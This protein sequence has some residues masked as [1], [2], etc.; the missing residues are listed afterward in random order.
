MIKTLKRSAYK[1]GY[2][3]ITAAWLYT[4][5]FIFI[6]YLSYTSSPA[7]VKQQFE[8]YLQQKEKQVADFAGNASVL[9][10][11]VNDRIGNSQLALLDEDE[12]K[13]FVYQVNDVGNLLLTFWNTHEAAPQTADLSRADGKYF[14]VYPNGE[15]E[16]VKKSL[17]VQRS[18]VVIVALIPIRWNFFFKN[19]YLKTTFSG[20]SSLEN[21]YE[22]DV[23]NGAIQIKNGDGKVLFGLAEKE[24]RNQVLYDK[25]SLTLR[26][27]SLI[28]LLIFFNVL[29]TDLSK[30]QGPLKGF[31]F[32]A[33]VIFIFR[34]LSYKFPIPFA[35]RHLE[36]FDP[37]IYASN[38]LHPSLGD[39]LI[40]MILLFWLVSFFKLTCLSIINELKPVASRASWVV[41][42]MLSVLLAGMSFF[43]AGVVRSLIV[44]SKI[45]FDISNFFSLSIYTFISFL[46]L[47]FITLSFF[48]L[49]H[50]ILLLLKKLTDVP[51]WGKFLT[52]TLTGLIYLTLTLQASFTLSNLCVLGWLLLY[53][54]IMEKRSPDLQKSLM[55]SSFFL[56]WLI[57]FAASISALIIYQNKVIELQVRKR[58]AEDLAVQTDPSG[59]NI[60][61]ITFINLNRA[62]LYDNFPRLL[63][64]ASNKFIKDSLINDNFSGYI[65]KYDTRIYTFNTD[66]KSLYNEDSVSYD[67][68]T[69]IIANRSKNTGIPDLYYHENNFESHSYIFQRAVKDFD[70][71]ILGY[72]FLVAKPKR[73]QSEALYPELFRQVKDVTSDNS[74]N[75]SYAVYDSGKLVLNEGDYNFV[76]QLAPTQWIRRETKE[77]SDGN[78]NILWYNAGSNK[79]IAIVKNGNIFFEVITLFAYLFGSFLFILILF[80]IG[81]VLLKSH[82]KW[83]NIKDGFR[84]N[85]RNQIQSTILI[86]SVFSF[87]VIGIATISFYIARFE[88][89]KKDRLSKAIR[90]MSKEIEKQVSA[91]EMFDDVVKIYDEGASSQLERSIGEISEIHDVDVNFYD[92]SGKLKVSTQPYIYNKQVLSNMMDPRA[93]YLLHN[94]HEIQ[95]IQQETVGR[96]SYLSIYVPVLN[97]EGQPYAYI[98]IPYLNSQNE[99][100][101]EISNFLVTLINVNAFIFVLAGVIAV[102]LTNRITNSL[103]LIGN[104]MKEV[105]LGSINEEISWDTDDEIGTLVN[106][107]N[108]MVQ[109]LD[110]SAQALAKSEREGA[111]REMARQVAHEIKNPLTPMKL[112]IQYLQ[113][114]IAEKKPGVQMLSEKVAATL[115]EQI[116]QLAKIASDFSQ[117]ANIE[118]ANNEVFNVSDVLQS[119]MA[120]Y[121][122]NEKIDLQWHK[123]AEPVMILADKTQVI[124]LFTN[125]LQN[126]IEA[127]SDKEMSTISIN[128]KVETG[129]VLISIRDE[130][131]GISSDMHEKIFTP[132]FTTKS[133]GTGLGLAISKGIVEKA[134]GEIW[135][136]T[137]ENDGTTF[138]VSFPVADN[139]S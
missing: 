48:H 72:F 1:N 31:L 115:V 9:S 89:N 110:E 23:E 30:K 20:I 75:Y 131:I 8:L 100:N 130:G 34:F 77:T 135:F 103:T 29:A 107:Y 105:N 117:F 101:Q 109:K 111:W 50:I 4:I 2:L 138:F 55:R 40:N 65:N 124:R 16:L 119:L 66:F 133:S 80:H 39:L 79:L 47:C 87:L 3:L 136:T 78:Y 35:Y 61:N 70:D 64:Q 12:P 33:G 36:L 18:R 32:L 60:L 14:V 97:D 92:L 120:L 68:L 76:S 81:S 71:N 106:E 122:S 24:K 128:Q 10:G 102:L 83:K 5:S 6:N 82:F 57:F 94:K 41:T 13:L 67:I 99:L 58:M 69:N 113:R 19:S 25:Y 90:I 108:K 104:K 129:H 93:Y 86:I 45:S 132:N 46:I 43:A 74:V 7:R 11:I 85:I 42:A 139:A 22:L 53:L 52:V 127:S 98:N 59:Q 62:F 44:D 38:D 56:I 137:S 118:H 125:L 84:P 17:I 27:F 91:H 49:S 121:S 88:N 15:F 51:D 73:Y 28:F 116:D 123:P 54:L 96:F 26:I 126:A 112:S 63:S 134:N 37:I 21:R 95:V 114:S